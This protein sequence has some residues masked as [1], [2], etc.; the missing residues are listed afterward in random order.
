MIGTDST[1][2]VIGRDVYDPN[3]ARIGSA[4]EGYLD[5]ETAAR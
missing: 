1:S 4:S 2:P 5:D 3:S